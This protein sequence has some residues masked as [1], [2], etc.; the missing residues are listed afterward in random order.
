M[1][2]L[3]L[4]IA[5]LHLNAKANNH[6]YTVKPQTP[7]VVTLVSNPST[8]YHWKYK[9]SM[10]G[11]KVVK[12]ISERYVPPKKGRPPGAAGKEV[13]HFRAVDKGKMD[14]NFLDMS[15]GVPSKAGEKVKIGIHVS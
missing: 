3:F 4:L 2:A 1:I 14:M 12:L 5:T 8:G 6:V 9:P 13:W 15:P 11:G 7:I 10:G